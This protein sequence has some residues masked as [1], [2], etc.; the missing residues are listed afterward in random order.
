MEVRVP[1][2]EGS[3]KMEWFWLAYLVTGQVGFAT[4]LDRERALAP[5]FLAR[6]AGSGGHGSPA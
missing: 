6:R 1:G 5:P 2:N 4:L 3:V